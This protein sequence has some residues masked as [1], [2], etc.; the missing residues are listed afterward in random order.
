MRWGPWRRNGWKSSPVNFD[1]SEW[2]EI[3]NTIQIH[4]LASDDEIE[5]HLVEA[6]L[7]KFSVTE[8]QPTSVINELSA[9]IQDII[10]TVEHKELRWME[11]NEKLES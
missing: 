6:G 9:K 8:G 1:L 3:T 10:D 2:I 11:L 7:D 5:G 4:F